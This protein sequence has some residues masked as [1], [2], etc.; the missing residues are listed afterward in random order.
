MNEIVAIL[1]PLAVLLAIVSFLPPIA[2]RLK[3]PYNVL[4]ALLGMGLGV[5]SLFLTDAD[6]FG[7]LGDVVTTLSQLN[8]TADTFLFIF[9][10]TLLFA[11]SLAMDV[12]RLFEEFAP[13]LLLAVVAVVVCTLSVG[14]SLHWIFDRPLLAC[15]LLGAVVAA[16]DPTAVVAI[17]RDL[18]APKKLSALVEGESLFNDAAAIALFTFIVAVLAGDQQ[19][20]LIS[21]VE[22][23]AA[24]LLGGIAVGFTLAW[25]TSRALRL[26][27]GFPMA[28][29]TLTLALAY[30]SYILA[31]LYFGVSGVVAVVTAGL[32]MGSAGRNNIPPESWDDLI[33]IWEQLDFWAASMIFIF[34]AM[35]IPQLVYQPGWADLAMLL[36]LV[37]AATAGRALVVYLLLPSLSL[38]GLAGKVSQ[39]HKIVIL[40]GGL[41]GAVTL[42]LALAVIENPDVPVEMEHFIATLA[43][44]F[45]LFT[46]FINGPTLRPLLRLLGLDKLS[47]AEV[48]LRDRVMALSRFTVHQQ[49]EVI[50][51]DYGIEAE[52]IERVPGPDRGHE[53]VDEEAEEMVLS[54]DDRL[55]IG[56]V[57]LTNREEELYRRHV[58]QRTI[59]RRYAAIGIA[60][61]GRLLDG[62]KTGG[63]GG[64]AAAAKRGAGLSLPFR[65]ALW[66][67]RNF[68]WSLPLSMQLA[69]RFEGLL[70]RQV[71]LRELR[72]F[73]RR[74][75]APVL[76]KTI[77]SKLQSILTTRLEADRRALRALDVQYPSYS[78]T[79]KIR[80]LGRSALRLEEAEYQLKR[81]EAM[82]SQ[83]VF[84]DLMR[85]LRL[86]RHLFDRRP[87][88]DLGMKLTE[89]I[90]QVPLFEAL[91]QDKL[92]V[93]AR[94][95][96][97][98]LAM[99][100]EKI[101]EEGTWGHSMYFIAS[102][103]VTVELKPAAVTLEEGD[104]FG[105]MALLHHR[106]RIADVI[107]DGFCH[108]LVLERGDFKRLA[109]SVPELRNK[110]WIVADE[111]A[112][113]PDR[114]S[115]E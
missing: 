13:I 63:L 75:V 24:G 115:T 81:D 31:E 66:I 107:S 113:P 98:R 45:V 26:L 11:G 102:G 15:L 5:T 30:L 72:L 111:R 18:G 93:L 95:L 41:R 50:A 82:I 20:D 16:T 23:F 12:R 25:L 22:A 87:P 88:L 92:T 80:Y 6:R 68:G 108:L 36:V 10:P 39:A 58:S 9:L 32:V 85:D 76:G 83:E 1:L 57:T 2:E 73:N 101:I 4:L 54:D 96:K 43:T 38:M 27:R 33:Q 67:H 42:A 89:M 17:F 61:S 99:P 112:H 90:R 100:G 14:Y 51:R 114:K 53:E 21:G 34:A 78:E 56:L 8:V 104:F 94:R 62:I 52:L 106:P 91:G 35:M 48:A 71:V 3:L 105:E 84:G 77:G 60:E 37:I 86:R 19:P 97:P 70:A 7:P 55:Q 29:I 109:K 65:A 69:G 74:S 64:Y 103:K 46:L 28:E 44:G 47:P 59:S 49:V 110:I 40:W 79:L